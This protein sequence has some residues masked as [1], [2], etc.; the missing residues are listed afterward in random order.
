MAKAEPG[1][2]QRDPAALPP[3][4]GT[5]AIIGLLVLAAHPSLDAPPP[6]SACQVLLSRDNIP[7]GAGHIQVKGSKP[8]QGP[9]AVDHPDM[10]GGV[11]HGLESLSLSRTPVAQ[12]GP[13][14]RKSIP[15][16]LLVTMRAV[17]R[18]ISA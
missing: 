17:W 4:L 15:H 16:S 8:F 13:G 12:V 6:P 9:D 10:G 1:D 5:A 3:A 18:S 14:D 11:P 7:A 2:G